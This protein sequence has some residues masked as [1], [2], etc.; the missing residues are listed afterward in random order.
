MAT[1]IRQSKRRWL[2]LAILCVGVFM[3][4]LD[5][6][7]VNIAV[8][9]IMTSLGTGFSEVEWV[10]NA[11]LLTFAV[12]LI[13]SGR[14]GDLYGRKAMFMAGLSV[15]S[16]ASLACGL[17][18]SVG[19]LIAFRAVQG[20]G[21]AMMMP[22]TLS[23][24]SNVFPPE[25]R[26][27]AMGFWGGVSG[28][29]LALGPSLGGLLVE[30]ASWRWIFFINVPIGLI[31]LP[32]AYRFVPESTE[33]GAAKQIDYPGVIVLTLSLLA[34]TFALIEG[35]NYGWTSPLII[36]LFAAAVIGLVVF[37]L[38]ERRQ[39]QPLMQLSLFKDRNFSTTNGIGLILSFGMMGVFFLLP[40]FL[41]AI[42]G[43]SAIK[44]GLVMTP[45][46]VVV[47]VAAPLS[48]TLSDRVGP[49]WLIFAGMLVT[50]LGFIL[51]RRVMV[52]DASW[53]SMVLPFAVAGFGIGMVMPVMTSAVMGSVPPEKAGQ[54]SGVLSS[55]RQIGSV[56]GHRGHGR[57]APESSRHLHRGRRGRATRRSPLPTAGRRGAA[58]HRCGGLVGRQHGADAVRRRHRRVASLRHA[59]DAGPG[60]RLGGGADH[61]VLQPTLQPGVPYDRVRPGHA[62]HLHLLHRPH[63]DRSRSRPPDPESGQALGGLPPLARRLADPLYSLPDYAVALYPT[64]R[65]RPQ[66]MS[67]PRLLVDIHRSLPAFTLNLRLEVGEE[68]LVLFGPSGAGKSMTL[69]SIAGLVT[70]DRERS[71]SMDECCS[72][73]ALRAHT[74]TCRRAAVALVTCFRATPSFLT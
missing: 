48:G 50:A 25:E 22:N 16:L 69:E 70:P 45:L 6:T 65:R 17:A 8:P 67:E 73:A 51:T 1:D 14:L 31:L 7:I 34:L 59:G 23:I 63:V 43:Y 61:E 19:F 40:V 32:V 20:V 36:S 15:F 72:V 62:H 3:L 37:V 35:Q 53:Q 5:G 64:G 9:N 66:T 18:P 26:G 52:P 2:V 12:L 13:T 30:A 58:D 47:I 33:P 57:G 44:A 55:V 11:Y 49:K 60:A 42:L 41:Q 29:S 27:K 74:P 24:I 56:L 68:V 39:S 28:I 4:L 71:S 38:I 21:G 54:A 46:A 10:M